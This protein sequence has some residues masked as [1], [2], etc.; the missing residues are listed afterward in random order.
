M[1]GL[2]AGATPAL[3]FAAVARDATVGGLLLRFLLMLGAAIVAHVLLARAAKWIASAVAPLAS[4][5]E[6]AVRYQRGVYGTADRG[7]RD[8][9]ILV[10]VAGVLMGLG[11]TFAPRWL[12]AVGAG[13]VVGA[14]VLDMLRWERASASANFVWFQR[15][16][17]RKLHQIAIENIRDVAVH[18]EE[19]PGFTLLHGR[20]NRI[21]RVHL[22]LHDKT[23]VSLPRTDA[24]RALD[25]VEA[26]A[27]HVR[28]RMQLLT[29][30]KSIE[31]AERDSDMAP[32]AAEPMLS[33]EERALRQELKRVRRQARADDA[34][35]TKT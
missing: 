29:E 19:A 26:L 2:A 25:D 24:A 14:V 12:V 15:G 33:P 5:E 9:V 31:R 35:D 7:A 23:I 6:E 10:L 17:Q 3:A 13:L 4:G 20:R 28:A 1:A 30:R 16:Y 18:E 27:N 34:L 11:A 32:L 8:I 22:K 21:C